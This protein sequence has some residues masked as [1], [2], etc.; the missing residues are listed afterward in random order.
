M[1][2]SSGE[3]RTRSSASAFER[4]KR[5]RWKL[6]APRALKKTNRRTPACSAAASRRW[7]PSA[8]ISSTF[9]GGWSRIA[10]A[11]WMTV[12]TPRTAFRSPRGIAEVGEREL[13]AD[14]LGPEPP[15]IADEAADLVALVQQHRQQC[16]AHD[17]GPSGQQNHRRQP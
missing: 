9:R 2:V 5:V 11:R 7:V 8:V 6:V 1:V 3:E 14:A 13:D 12:S 15:R 16:R 17:T 4:K 10:A